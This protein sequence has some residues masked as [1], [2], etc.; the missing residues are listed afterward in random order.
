MDKIPFS[1]IARSL[2][3][4]SLEGGFDA[5]SESMEILR[6][7]EQGSALGVSEYLHGVNYSWKEFCKTHSIDDTFKNVFSSWYDTATLQRKVCSWEMLTGDWIPKEYLDVIKRNYNTKMLNASY[8]VILKHFQNPHVGNY[9]YIKS[10]L[11]IKTSDYLALSECRD[12]PAVVDAVK[13]I[14]G[15]D[16]DKNK[17]SFTVRDNGDIVFYRGKK[18][19]AVVGHLNVISD[20]A[21]VKDGVSEVLKKL[22]V[23][24]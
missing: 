10:G 22:G 17:V 23:E 18:D 15:E 16:P 5:V 1:E 14:K 2:V 3:G 12:F 19:Q 24:K 13:K 7:M 21:L 20:S 6:G 8:R 4:Q 11:D 9:E